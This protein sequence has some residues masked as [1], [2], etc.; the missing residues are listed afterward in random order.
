MPLPIAHGLV[1]ACIAGTL[2]HQ[3]E[4]AFDPKPWFLGAALGILPDMDLVFYWLLEFPQRSHRGFSHSIIV[5][6]ALGVATSLVVGGDRIRNSIIYT[7]ATLSHSLLDG[8]TTQSQGGV[9]LLWPFSDFRFKLGL[10]DYP[11]YSTIDPTIQPLSVVLVKAVQVSC[12]EALV[13][14]P[15]IV[16]ALLISVRRT[17]LLKLKGPA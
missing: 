16:V 12:I 14:G 8:L 2:Q 11:F 15:M 4:A 13:F 7:L 17:H 9:E 5:A 6:L 1:G 10:F 3:K